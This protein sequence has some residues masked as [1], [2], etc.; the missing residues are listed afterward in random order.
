MRCSAH[1]QCH[2][3]GF[4]HQQRMQASFQ[5]KDH[6]GAH[7]RILHLHIHNHFSKHLSPHDVYHFTRDCALRSQNRE[8]STESAHRLNS[9]YEHWTIHLPRSYHV[10]TQPCNSEGSQRDYPI[11]CIL[12]EGYKLCGCFNISGVFPHTD[13]GFLQYG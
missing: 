13:I 10:L 6:D 4:C 1:S 12:Q 8:Y 3:F 11:R 7:R 2:N 9:Y 5:E